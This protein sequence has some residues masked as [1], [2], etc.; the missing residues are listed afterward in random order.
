MPAA[1]LS[2]KGL[3]VMPGMIDHNHQS[4]IGLLPFSGDRRNTG[5]TQGL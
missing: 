3:T 1:E 5:T 2:K 4:E